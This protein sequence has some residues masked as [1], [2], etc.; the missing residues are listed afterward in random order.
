[1]ITSATRLSGGLRRIRHP[2]AL[3][4]LEPY[5]LRPQHVVDFF[6]PAHQRGDFQFEEGFDRLG[7]VAK[8]AVVDRHDADQQR[9]HAMRGQNIITTDIFDAGEFIRDRDD[10]HPVSLAFRRVDEQIL[11]IA[12]APAVLQR[13]EDR[14]HAIA[15]LP[16][17]NNVTVLT[18]GRWADQQRIVRIW[19]ATWN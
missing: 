5:R 8:P 18:K 12:G 7:D 3:E 1:M 19:L 4:R 14:F 13:L 15:N 6:E 10:F 11:K 9:W 16:A 2:Y 17:M